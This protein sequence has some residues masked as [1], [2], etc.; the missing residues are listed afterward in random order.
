MSVKVITVAEA[1]SWCS[2][3]G[4][5]V[6]RGEPDVGALGLEGISFNIP[7]DAGARIM[8][9]GLLYPAVWGIQ[10]PILIWTTGWS[11][12]PSGEHVPLFLRLREALGDRRSLE[13][14][15]AQI[16]E[17][18]SRSDG[19]SIVILHSLF[20]W[21]CWVVAEDS[22]YI[23]YLCHD[24]WGQVYCRSRDIH[25]AVRSEIDRM[26]LLRS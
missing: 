24:E 2:R 23:L 21:D 22:N 1:E 5:R 13:E 16:V 26:G 9:S 17:E 10:G 11:V 14:A 3:N 6:D 8:L 12:W 4:L 7:E 20:L 25:E 18:D 15:S 19:E